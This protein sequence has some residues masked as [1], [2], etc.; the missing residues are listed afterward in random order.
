[1]FDSLKYFHLLTLLFQSPVVTC[2]RICCDGEGRLNSSS[3]LLEGC[4]DLNKGA[5]VSLNLSKLQSYS[6]FPGQVII[7][8]GTNVT[9]SQFVAQ[10]I[11]TDA[12]YALPPAPE[13]L[14]QLQGRVYVL[15]LTFEFFLFL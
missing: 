10:N 11:Y 7:A 6:I 5:T 9:G 12:T 3:V 14:Q 4:T 13:K 2:G 8:Q 1:M 15:E